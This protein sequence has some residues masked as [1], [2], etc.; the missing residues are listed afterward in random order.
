MRPISDHDSKRDADLV[1]AYEQGR[2]ERNEA[3]RAA[4]I[5]ELS[6]YR[7]PVVR[8][9]IYNLAMRLGIELEVS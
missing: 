3:V 6:R 4:F 8:A 1:S 7:E 9:T 5:E 2:L